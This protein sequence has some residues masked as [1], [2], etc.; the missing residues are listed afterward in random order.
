MEGMQPLI[1]RLANDPR[2]VIVISAG[3][4]R[5]DTFAD[6]DTYPALLSWTNKIITMGSVMASIV[7]NNGAR[8]SCSP[9]GDVFTVRAPGN[10]AS[11][12][13][14]WGFLVVEALRNHISTGIVS[15][16]GTYFRSLPD[17]GARLRRKYK[18]PKAVIDYLRAMSY[19]G[20][21]R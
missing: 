15:G 8:Y 4:K 9:G 5:E 7:P 21:M 6:I 16:L 10:A 3:F 19:R 13:F 1:N 11:M 20:G 12:G 14:S 18:T 17:L 2:A